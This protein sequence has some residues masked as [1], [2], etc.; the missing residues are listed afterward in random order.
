MKLQNQLSLKSAL[1]FALPCFASC[2]LLAACSNDK[3]EVIPEPLP[4]AASGT[5]RFTASAPSAFETVTTR[6][7][8]DGDNKP[9]VDNYEQDEPVVWVGG[10][11][12]SVFFVPKETGTVVHAKF[13]IDDE[14]ITNGG[15]SAELVSVSNLG[16]LDGEYTIYAI[17]PYQSDN[18]LVESFLDLSNQIQDADTKNYSHL[19]NTASMRA[20]GGDASFA[21]GSLTDGDINFEF[22]HLT[23]ILR[24]HVVNGTNENLKITDISFTSSNISSS[25]KLHAGTGEV[26]TEIDLTSVNL[27]IAS[28]GQELAPTTGADF[29]MSVL[30]QVVDNTDEYFVITVTTNSKTNPTFTYSA[31]VS[32]LDLVDGFKSSQRFLFDLFAP[33]RPDGFS[34]NVVTALFNNTFYTTGSVPERRLYVRTHPERPNYVLYDDI[35]LFCP[36]SW[37]PMRYNDVYTVPPSLRP[38][39]IDAVKLI[40]LN[41]RGNNYVFGYSENCIVPTSPHDSSAFSTINLRTYRVQSHNFTFFLNELRRF[42][43]YDSWLYG[44]VTD[45]YLSVLNPDRYFQIRCF[46]TL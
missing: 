41:M 45:D 35:D 18:S 19:G 40:A 11:A 6:I 34:E 44:E 36:D 3:S 13:I 32:D 24:F 30:P 21:N 22:E 7:G 31:L 29:Y 17:T 26:N 42:S 38:A 33:S 8:I 5:I 23:S 27:E 15:K 12:L 9:T 25:A 14:T 16:V 39:L 4:S 2:L 10:E 37:Q 46:S 1:R 43:T 20:V 28:G